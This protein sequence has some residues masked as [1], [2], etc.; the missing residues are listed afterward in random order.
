MTC[1]APNKVG[2]RNF[3]EYHARVLNEGVVHRGVPSEDVMPAASP[4][5]LSEGPYTLVRHC[6]RFQGRR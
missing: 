4:R 1:G 6:L 3:C 5:F 2:G